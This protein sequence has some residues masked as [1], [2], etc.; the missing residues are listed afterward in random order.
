[1]T[2]SYD[3]VSR[4]SSLQRPNGVTTAYSYD[5]AY[6]L[7]R[8]THTNSGG[9]PI[10]D[11]GFSYDLDD[12]IAAIT[13]LASSGSLPQALTAGPADA[14]NR[15]GQSAAASFKFDAEGQTTSKTDSTGTASYQWDARG[16]LIQAT[17]PGNQVVS[18][19]YDAVGRR[20][21]R[22]ASGVTT[23]LLY[24]GIDVVLDKG[25]DGS[26]VD[27]LN[28]LRADEKLR[29]KSGSNSLYFLTDPLG[30]TA[31]LTDISGNVAEREQYGPFGAA[32][33]P[34]QLTRYGYTG[35]ELDSTTGLMHYRARWYDPQ[36]GRFLT[37]DPASFTGGLN[38]YA[39][40]RGQP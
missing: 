21:S 16:R 23:T 33:S 8:L 28:G 26:S 36:Q 27:Y 24:D 19:S 13:S 10:E 40:R 5:P 20:A 31:A 29:Q 9:Q 6:R 3:T 35:R 32:M 39:S 38:F 25:S 37:E 22:T 12:Q 7:T 1:F 14:A 4:R 2:L 11:F 30:S 17:L 15:L 18:Y 34:S